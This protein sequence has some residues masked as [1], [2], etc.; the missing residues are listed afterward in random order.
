MSDEA[1]V[2]AAGGRCARR[3]RPVSAG[4]RRL[5]GYRR[6]VHLRS[7]GAISQVRV[8][9]V[10][11]RRIGVTGPDP[12]PAI[13]VRSPGS[14]AKDDAV[15][16]RCALRSAGARIALSDRDTLPPADSADN[17]TWWRRYA[18]GASPI[19]PSTTR[20]S[21]TPRWAS[22]RRARRSPAGGSRSAGEAVPPDGH[23]RCVARPRSSRAG[24]TDSAVNTSNTD[25]RFPPLSETPDTG[26]GQRLTAFDCDSRPDHVALPSATT[27]AQ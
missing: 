16:S 2:G 20:G 13:R 12:R 5:A 19:T 11:R 1:H 15:P 4:G 17:A 25:S 18:S 14:Q 8:D 7:V 27:D 23:W 9:H 6:L 3:P 10:T 24:R 21:S 22:Q 26:K